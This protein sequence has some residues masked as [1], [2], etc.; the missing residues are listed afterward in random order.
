LLG[1]ILKTAHLPG[2]GQMAT[3][4]V[5]TTDDLVDGNITSIAALIATPGGAGISLRE[6]ILAANN[7][8]GADTIDL[9]GVTGTILLTNAS[10]QLPITQSVTINGPGATNL[11]VSGNN[12]VRVFNISGTTTVNIDGMTIANGNLAGN[13]AGIQV[14]AASTLNL[15]N[16]TVSSNTATGVG[17]RGDGIYN[18]VGK[19]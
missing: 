13:S 9:T 18:N 16:S 10:R 4:S 7:T 15:S 11:T 12:A 5:T 17:S 19:I 8:A 3:V 14:A 2:S 6:A 1:N